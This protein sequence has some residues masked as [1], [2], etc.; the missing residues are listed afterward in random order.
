M[1]VKI[2]FWM[3]ITFFPW[4]SESDEKVRIAVSLNLGR[5]LD[6]SGYLLSVCLWNLG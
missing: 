1:K 4:S 6:F 5:V 3:P 2:Y